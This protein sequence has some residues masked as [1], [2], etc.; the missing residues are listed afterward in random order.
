MFVK[1]R[2]NSINLTHVVRV[3]VLS[4]GALWTFSIQF[5]VG[6]EL[7]WY[8]LTRAVAEEYLD[9]WTNLVCPPA[10]IMS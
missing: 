1:F 3:S 5:T 4:D 2:S 6:S 9:T 10:L 8:G 7:E